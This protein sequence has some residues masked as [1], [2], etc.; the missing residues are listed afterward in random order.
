MF[1]FN[2]N[3]STN[4]KQIISLKTS[5]SHH[6]RWIMHTRLSFGKKNVGYHAELSEF[7]FHVQ[8][9]TALNWRFT[10]AVFIKIMHKLSANCGG[11][12]CFSVTSFFSE[13]TQ[14]IFI[15]F[16]YLYYSRE[17]YILIQYIGKLW[18]TFSHEAD[19]ELKDHHTK[20]YFST[21]NQKYRQN[22]ICSITRAFVSV[23]LEIRLD[24]V[25]LCC[26]SVRNF[27]IVFAVNEHESQCFA[28]K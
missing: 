20:S 25:Q 1:L 15:K 3:M 6:K 2:W 18:R 27:E 5:H 4:L 23:N 13:I 8:Q 28:E 19:V 7:G 14:G 24:K 12:A 22:H 26:N 16:G 9:S 17:D 10:Y 11:S 21:I